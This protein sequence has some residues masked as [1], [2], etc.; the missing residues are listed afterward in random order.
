M[1]GPWE[2]YTGT[3]GPTGPWDQYRKPAK[4]AAQLKATDPSEYDP[5]SPAWQEKYGATSGNTGWQNFSQG[6]ERRLAQIGRGTKQALTEGRE[7]MDPFGSTI[8]RVTGTP[9]PSDKLR[10][11]ETD[12]RRMEAPLFNTRGG[13]AGGLFADVGVGVLSSRIP[14]ANTERGVALTGGALGGVQPLTQGESR[15]ES[16]A[17]GAGTSLLANEVVGRL[18]DAW[19]TAAQNRAAQR[20]MTS[21]GAQA[22]GSAQA[23]ASSTGGGAGSA[24]T[25]T[26]NPQ[27]SAR[28]GISFGT[29]GEAPSAGLTAAQRN[30]LER[31][32]ELGMRVTPGQALG[33]KNVQRVEAKLES[34]PMTAGTFDAIKDNNLRVVTREYAREIGEDTDEITRGVLGRAEDRIG[35][36]FNRVLDE[37]D[38]QY[39]NNLQTRLAELEA[40]AGNELVP[41]EMTVINKQLSSIL[42]KATRTDNGAISGRAYQNI[43][44]S[45][46]RIAQGNRPNLAYYAGQLR[47]TLDD[48]LQNSVSGSE[49][50]ALREA[51]RQWRFLS[52]GTERQGAINIGTGRVSPG[53]MTS[54]VQSADEAGFLFGGRQSRFYDALEFSKAFQPLVGDSGTATR[55]PLSI[56]EMALGVPMR[57]ATGAYASAPSVNLAV[58]AQQ[59]AGAAARQAADA[60]GM[61]APYL[62]PYLPR[63]VAGPAGLLG[64]YAGQKEPQ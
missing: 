35:G 50:A 61:L 26:A 15:G 45:L 22:S 27:M 8:A 23:A 7:M 30:V 52:I 29:A 36:V 43:R 13:K 10:D 59:S 33:N 55:M 37:A 18:S 54:A 64:A 17:L 19:S 48:A 57:I 46:N 41:E 62:A 51:R 44:T 5:E 3:A 56:S 31:G 63:T 21:S 9:L 14:G 34:Q 6:V 11:A 25:I 24:T 32:R 60:G 4:T 39:T 28:T 40:R 16:A 12:Q 58:S 38:I 49:A 47:N 42:D 1:A 2:K 20:A 53:A